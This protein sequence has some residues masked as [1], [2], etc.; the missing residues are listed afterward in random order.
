M[1]KKFVRNS[2]IKIGCT[3]PV[4]LITVLYAFWLLGWEGV[5]L[6]FLILFSIFLMADSQIFLFMVK[7]AN[8]DKKDEESEG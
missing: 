7:W 1:M 4:V 2:K 8:L 5:A 3:I 6:I